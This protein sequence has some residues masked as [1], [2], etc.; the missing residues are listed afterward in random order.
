MTDA[1]SLNLRK[2]L[3]KFATGVTVVTCRSGDGRSCGITANSFSSVSL[4]PPLIL[5]NIAKTCNSLDAFL[6]AEHYAIHVLTND[7]IHLAS[8]F[9][10]TDHKSYERIV[11]TISDDGVPILP[12]V[13]AR[14]D[15]RTYQ[16]HDSGDHHIIVG[17]VLHHEH[18][19]GN[20]LLYFSSN[21]ASL[22]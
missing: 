19:A 17:E 11:H 18:R 16:I 8:H 15:C 22:D 4:D 20:P 10:Q 5:W 21:Y 9:A 6:E 7:Q 14:F 1:T 12:D 2:S 3:G 13:L